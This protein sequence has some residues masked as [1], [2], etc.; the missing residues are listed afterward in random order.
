M[1]VNALAQSRDRLRQ[2]IIMQLLKLTP[3]NFAKSLN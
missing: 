1:F 2:Y 3:G